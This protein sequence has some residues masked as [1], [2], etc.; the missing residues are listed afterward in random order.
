VKR[1]TPPLTGPDPEAHSQIPSMQKI[2]LGNAASDEASE[3]E[4]SVL[5]R[6]TPTEASE[7]TQLAVARIRERKRALDAGEIE[8]GDPHPWDRVPEAPHRDDFVNPE[9]AAAA[10]SV[11]VQSW[12]VPSH[13]L[14]GW[15][16]HDRIAQELSD[17]ADEALAQRERPAQPPLSR[18]A[19]WAVGVVL[20]S[21]AVIGLG[22]LVIVYWRWA[23]G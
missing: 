5:P 12:H 20:L 4:L 2:N 17:A 19:R 1:P 21:A 11:G 14:S 15:E 23:L 18:P 22:P 13:A 16:E 6:L 3:R 8:L 7:A 10:R 9:D